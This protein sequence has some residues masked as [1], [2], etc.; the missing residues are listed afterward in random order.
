MCEHTW[1]MNGYLVRP[2]L[3]QWDEL[4]EKVFTTNGQASHLLLY[5]VVQ[6]GVTFTNT[7]PVFQFSS[8]VDFIKKQE[9]FFRTQP[10]K[11]TKNHIW[12][13]RTPEPIDTNNVY[14]AAVAICSV[15]NK[16]KTQFYLNKMKSIVVAQGKEA[17]LLDANG[18]RG[19]EPFTV[20]VPHTHQFFEKPM[21]IWTAPPPPMNHPNDNTNYYEVYS[22]PWFILEGMISPKL[23][24][25]F[26]WL[27]G[28]QIELSFHGNPNKK[29]IIHSYN[30]HASGQLSTKVYSSTV[31]LLVD[32][33]KLCIQY[34][35][36]NM[37]IMDEMVTDEPEMLNDVT[38][39]L[40]KDEVTFLKNNCNVTYTF[41]KEVVENDT[42][43]VLQLVKNLQEQSPENVQ[44]HED[45]VYELRLSDIWEII[46]TVVKSNVQ[47]RKHSVETQLSK[48]WI[49]M[50]PKDS[51]KASIDVVF[52]ILFAPIQSC[53]YEGD[54]V[55]VSEPVPKA[56]LHRMV[57]AGTLQGRSLDIV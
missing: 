44:D 43:G 12:W 22:K 8:L 16:S 24:N 26:T 47:R 6:A 48:H 25:N 50:K 35:V 54:F 56:E 32:T 5:N 9:G 55:P 2:S 37:R 34:A 11:D 20:E 51:S 41:T 46:D 53:P 18:I 10:V 23:R 1:K 3:P 57:E 28:D 36:E 31:G 19:K 21:V 4:A 14:V 45:N 52:A 38:R 40:S 29:S 13:V 39:T 17:N 7:D 42:I 49:E 15:E 33:V 27:R 30:V